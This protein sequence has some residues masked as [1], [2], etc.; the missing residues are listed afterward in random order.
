MR[1]GLQHRLFTEDAWVRLAAVAT[2]DP[3]E[4]VTSFDPDVQQGIA[5]I[6]VLVTGWGSPALTAS[7]LSAMP[8]LR[9]VVHAAGSVK[10]HLPEDF[11]R[12]HI[13]VSSAAD[14]NAIPVAEYTLATIILANKAILPIADRYRQ[15]RAHRDWDA[16]YPR[17]GNYRKRVGVVGASKI[18]RRVLALLQQLSVEVVVADPYLD[19]DAARAMGAELMD[20]DDLVA[21]SDVVSLHAPDI[22]ET[23]HLMNARR[24]AS[25]RAGATL[26]NT[27]R[28]ALVDH[29][30][31]VEELQTGRINAVLD[32]TTPEVLAAD[33][34][35][36]DLPNVLLTP[37]VAG[38]LGTELARLGDSAVVEVERLAHGLP[39]L[40]EVDADQLGRS[41]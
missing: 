15:E 29:D 35:L 8:R 11:W 6:D 41:A 39:M 32:V 4:T 23:Q 12:H 31:L 21:S 25:M 28:G 22:P 10:P 24:L 30:A 19:P 38:S 34:P 18:G 3:N 27:A 7:A 13:P 40:T 2:V 37:H 26:I 36:Y 20:L 17:M 9:A 5:D 1:P 14:A 16:L 33:S